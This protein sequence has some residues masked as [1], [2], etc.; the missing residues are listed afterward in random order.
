MSGLLAGLIIILALH[1]I[2]KVAEFIVD[3]LK[4]KNELTEKNIA[5][6][7]SALSLNTEAVHAL[8]VRMRK[9]E[10]QITE[11]SKIKIDIRRLFLAIKVLAGDQWTDLKKSIT[12]DDFH[13]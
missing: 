9:V 7:I 8:E 12:E 4:K 3:V 11:A 5:H 1:L 13:N 2:V 10:D 6:L